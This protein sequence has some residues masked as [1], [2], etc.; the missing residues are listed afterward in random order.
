MSGRLSP[1]SGRASCYNN[2]LASHHS[3]TFNWHTFGTWSTP[4]WLQAA[5]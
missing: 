2:D 4:Q 3:E 1:Y 5:L